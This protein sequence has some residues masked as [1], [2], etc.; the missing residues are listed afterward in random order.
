MTRQRQPLPPLPDP[1]SV[2]YAVIGRADDELILYH[3]NLPWV[4][5]DQLRARREMA[6]GRPCFVV[7]MSAW[8]SNPLAALQRAE[9]ERFGTD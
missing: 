5:A 7:P 2:L 8:H 3:M 6:T 9:R 1:S 4:R